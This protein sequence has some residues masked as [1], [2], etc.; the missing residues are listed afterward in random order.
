MNEAINPNISIMFEAML[1]AI[2]LGVITGISLITL[3]APKST[4]PSKVHGKVR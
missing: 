4:K 3:F 1:T 2:T